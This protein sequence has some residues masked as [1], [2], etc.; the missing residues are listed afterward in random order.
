MHRVP[1]AKQHA[2]LVRRGPNSSVLL[3][4]AGGAGAAG[5][6]PVSHFRAWKG[7]P[8]RQ[9]LGGEEGASLSQDVREKR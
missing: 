6:C 2:R 9:A 1:G 8:Q 4:I 5:C 7:F 3:R